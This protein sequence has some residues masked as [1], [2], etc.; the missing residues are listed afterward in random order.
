MLAALL[1]VL[2]VFALILAGWLAGR[3]AVLGPHA[4]AVATVFPLTGLV[5]PVPAETFLR[6]LGGAA[7]PC[8]LVALGLFVA[9]NRPGGNPTQIP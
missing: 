5:L 2:P 4:T 9:S 7:A 8:A 3:T 6:L 1:I